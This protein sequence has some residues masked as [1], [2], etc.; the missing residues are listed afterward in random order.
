[1]SEK[2]ADLVSRDAILRMTANIVAAYI[3]NNTTP[4]EQVPGAIGAVFASLNGL[5]E[6]TCEGSAKPR[7]PAVPINRSVTPDYIICLEDGRKM[8]L[9]QRHLRAAFDLSPEEYRA[10]WK[11]PAGYPM[12]AA[13]YAKRRSAFAKKFGL[14]LNAGRQGSRGLRRKPS[15]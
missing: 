4:L 6:M 7:K 13:N 2:P 9:L 5:R 8:K 10:K 12:V 14:G 11:L 15:Q 1:M 3:N